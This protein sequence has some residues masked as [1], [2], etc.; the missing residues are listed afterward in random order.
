MLQDTLILNFYKLA[1]NFQLSNSNGVNVKKFI[2]FHNKTF[3]TYRESI[4]SMLEAVEFI[5][6]QQHY[7]QYLDQLHLTVAVA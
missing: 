1:K 5:H 2:G 4:H 3:D 6:F 7:T